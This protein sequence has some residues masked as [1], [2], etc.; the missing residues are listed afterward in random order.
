MIHNFYGDYASLSL[1]LDVQ[2]TDGSKETFTTDESWKASY[3]PILNS[4]LY[5]GSPTMLLWNKTVGILPGFV[6]T[7][8]RKAR[9][10]ACTSKHIE[11][12]E[13]AS[14]TLHEVISPP[15]AFTTRNGE[16]VIDFDKI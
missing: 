14:V 1:R 4:Q 2:Y 7:A 5:D 13:G 8:W 16:R 10:T 6:D 11:A 9:R 15:L 12:Q 3:S